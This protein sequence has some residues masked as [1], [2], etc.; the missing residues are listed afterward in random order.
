[1]KADADNRFI[2]SSYLNEILGNFYLIT[3]HKNGTSQDAEETLT[4]I[5]YLSL[6]NYFISIPAY[7]GH[8]VHIQHA[9]SFFLLKWTTINKWITRSSAIF[10]YDI[11]LHE[12]LIYMMY[13]YKIMYT[14]K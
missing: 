9:N 2:N 8:L 14:T 12:L 1:M 13:A 6:E 4:N 7:F 10:H 5:P 3:F 11:C